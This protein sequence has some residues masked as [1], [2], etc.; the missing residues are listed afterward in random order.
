MNDFTLYLAA[1]AAVNRFAE[2]S[3][4]YIDKFAWA[5]QT[6]KS[7]LVLI[8]VLAGVL[9]ALMSNLNLFAG[10]GRLPE[11]AGVI[12]TG[13]LAGFGADVINAFVDLL[14][15]WKNAAA[16]KGEIVEAIDGRLAQV[17]R[18]G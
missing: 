8:S 17:E 10:I 6:R 1:A 14:Y 2:F 7:V 15:G 4:G 3:K 16:R 5:E 9:I 18:I 13:V 11:M 12:L